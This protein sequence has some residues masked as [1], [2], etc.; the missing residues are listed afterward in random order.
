MDKN[1]ENLIE[2]Y[3]SLEEYAKGMA[4][5]V[6]KYAKLVVEHQHDG[7]S[8]IHYE[9]AK[10]S[11]P[12]AWFNEALF[13]NMMLERSEVKDMTPYSNGYKVELSD[14]YVKADEEP[15]RVLDDTDVQ[16]MCAKHVLWLNGEGGEQADFANCLL[17][18]ID[19][20]HKNLMAAVFDDA[21]FVNVKLNG[22]SLVN[23]SFNGARFIGCDLSYAVAEMCE[24]K[25]ARFIETDVECVAFGDS[26]LENSSFI[27][28][29]VAGAIL[30]GCNIQNSDLSD[31]DKKLM[32]TEN[33]EDNEEYNSDLQDFGM[34]M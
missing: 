29:K 3:P 13:I 8:R 32:F 4:A 22:A 10:K 25:S 18:N 20:R 11:S 14:E 31:E 19:L 34:S 17:K 16:V 23:S 1:I 27:D 6:D 9:D 26:N 5:L 12:F 2:Q 7:V 28:C 30:N 24:F 15:L 33:T 21:K